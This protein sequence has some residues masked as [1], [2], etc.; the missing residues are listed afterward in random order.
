MW[1]GSAGNPAAMLQAFRW[2]A[3]VVTEPPEPAPKPVPIQEMVSGNLYSNKTY[4]FSMYKPPAWE[5]L[6]DRSTMPE[7]ITA[8]GTSDRSTLLVIGRDTFAWPAQPTGRQP[9]WTRAPPPRAQ[10]PRHPNQY[11]PLTLRHLNIAGWPAVEQHFRGN[12]DGHDWSVV[13]VT[14][15]RTASVHHSGYDLRGLRSHPAAKKT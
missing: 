14:L 4:G 15:L 13:A 3:P 6:S 10:A 11:R 12:A 9:V 8:L 1:R 2:R 5:I 7:A